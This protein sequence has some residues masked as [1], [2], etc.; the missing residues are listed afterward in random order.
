MRTTSILG[1]AACAATAL[2]SAVAVPAATFP[3]PA[4][5]F[6][7]TDDGYKASSGSQLHDASSE[8]TNAIRVAA[9]I[10]VPLIGAYPLLFMKRIPACDPGISASD[11]TPCG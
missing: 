3:P 4:I 9:M 11:R 7:V 2:S 10:P 8:L 5:D 6:A 1:I